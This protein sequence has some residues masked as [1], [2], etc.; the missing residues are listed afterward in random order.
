[1]VKHLFLEK[2]GKSIYIIYK[3]FPD[4][5]LTHSLVVLAQLSI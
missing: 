5:T 1:M 4:W 2:E 3:T